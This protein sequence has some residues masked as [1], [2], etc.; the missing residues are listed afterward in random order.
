MI[1][2]NELTDCDCTEITLK[3]SR[4]VEVDNNMF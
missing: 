1:P 4:N 3:A 2:F